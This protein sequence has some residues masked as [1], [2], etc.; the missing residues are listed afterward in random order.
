MA[1]EASN[2]VEA[3]ESAQESAARWVTVLES[4]QLVEKWGSG[5]NQK[6][7]LTEKGNLK[8]IEALKLLI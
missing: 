6:V 7:A 8:T 2:A 4:W 3:P 1:R 5:D